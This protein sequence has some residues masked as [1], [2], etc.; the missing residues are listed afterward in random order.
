MCYSKI[1]IAIVIA[2]LG[3]VMEWFMIRPKGG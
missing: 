2:K 1:V 3:K